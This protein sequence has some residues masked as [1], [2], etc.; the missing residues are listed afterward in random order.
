MFVDVKPESI[1]DNK[2]RKGMRHT[3]ETELPP[4]YAAPEMFMR[5]IFHLV[6]SRIGCKRTN[7]PKQPSGPDIKQEIIESVRFIVRRWWKRTLWPIKNCRCFLKAGHGGAQWPWVH[8]FEYWK[9]QLLHVHNCARR[10]RPLV[11][12][13]HLSTSGR[14]PLATLFTGL[15]E[16]LVLILFTIFLGAQWGGNLFVVCYKIAV[17]LIVVTAGRAL[18]LWYVLKSTSIWG[19]HV[20]ECETPR[21][22]Q[23]CLRIMCSMKGVLVFVYGAYYF[24]G[25]RLDVR[26][27]WREWILEYEDG[28]YD[29]GPSKP[30]LRQHNTGTS[31]SSVSLL[32]ASRTHTSHGS[33]FSRPTFS[34]TVTDISLRPLGATGQKGPATAS[35][36]V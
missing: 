5:L 30:V 1:K 29:E 19:L 18:G 34:R 31:S 16:G 9:T 10:Y 7:K 3:T 4:L 17:L 12:L 14:N 15:V 33:L 20:L 8:N 13:M 32:Q 25:Y 36:Y 28:M 6:W 11:V 27:G 35:D 23:G 26:D 24:E 2:S 22:I 21:D